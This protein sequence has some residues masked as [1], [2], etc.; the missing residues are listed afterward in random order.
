MAEG[1]WPFF[2]S[3]LLSKSARIGCNYGQAGTEERKN[4]SAAASDAGPRHASGS[5][6]NY[7]EETEKDEEAEA[8][9]WNV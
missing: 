6:R 4:V 8:T 1:M 2:F 5:E 7:R 9:I 3:P